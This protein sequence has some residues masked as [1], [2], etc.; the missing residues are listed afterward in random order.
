MENQIK[1]ITKE[2]ERW[3][4]ETVKH[5]NHVEYYLNELGL[6]ERDPERPHDLVGPGNKLEWDIIKGMALNYRTPKVDFIKY[7]LPSIE[8]HRQQ[9]H[10]RMW[11]YPNPKATKED[12]FVGAV[13]AV[14]SLLENR[15]YQG[16]SHNWEK[17]EDILINRNPPHKIESVKLIL[18]KMRKV[19]LPNLEDI[20]NVFILPNIGV[21]RGIYLK[22]RKRIDK[23]VENLWGQKIHCFPLYFR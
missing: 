5:S 2:I 10:H 17:I 1:P 9:Y 7:I 18:P 22:M 16:G 4:F 15:D 20:P 12:M 13:D 23:A 8:I 19:P 14:C 21:D 3:I 6:G 11:N